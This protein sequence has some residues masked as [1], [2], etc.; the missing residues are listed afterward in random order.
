VYPPSVCAAAKRPRPNRREQYAAETRTAIIH[1]ARRLFAE[2]GYFATRVDQIAELASVAP[3]TVY[4]VTK[5]KQGLL[6][7][8]IDAWST[9]PRLEDYYH[10]VQ[11]ASDAD[12]VLRVTAQGTRETR[13]EWADVMRVVLA[14]APHDEDAAAGLAAA[15][16]RYRAAFRL[17]ADRL[18]ALGGTSLKRDRVVDVLWFYFGYA[19]YFTLH[20]DNGWSF[21]E[22]EQ[23]LLEQVRGALKLKRPR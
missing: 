19:S 5:G 11:D 15:T 23:W 6:R 10:R 17:V 4:A 22:A 12:E 16:E 18:I 13:E 8:L 14:T 20:D 7:T 3:A 1:A 9:S 21:A 2:H